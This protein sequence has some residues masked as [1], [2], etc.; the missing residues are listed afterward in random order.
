VRALPVDAITDEQTTPSATP[1]ASV[2]PHLK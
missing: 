2:G 1:K